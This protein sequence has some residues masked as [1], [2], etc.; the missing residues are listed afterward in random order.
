MCLYMFVYDRKVGYLNLIL[1]Y[2]GEKDNAH[3]IYAFKQTLGYADPSFEFR[4]VCV[5]VCKCVIAEMAGLLERT[6]LED[7]FA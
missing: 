3:P 7:S 2:R 1:E 6:I 4:D 5:C